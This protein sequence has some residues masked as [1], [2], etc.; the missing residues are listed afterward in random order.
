MPQPCLL[1]GV[2]RVCWELEGI[3]HFGMPAREGTGLGVASVHYL[4]S[5]KTGKRWDSRDTEGQEYKA[6]VLG[7]QGTS[8]F[9]ILPP[10]P[11]GRLIGHNQ[12]IWKQ[13]RIS[14]SGSGSQARHT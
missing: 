12:P 2:L 11:W 13:G 3:L 10:W 6:M 8:I 14:L 7:S 4:A 9:G 5:L 1:P